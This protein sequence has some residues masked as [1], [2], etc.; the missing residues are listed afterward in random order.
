VFTY[1]THIGR[2]FLSIVL[3]QATVIKRAQEMSPELLEALPSLKTQER[4][5]AMPTDIHAQQTGTA[6]LLPPRDN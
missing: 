2:K 3:T 5:R 6:R 4:C 1:L